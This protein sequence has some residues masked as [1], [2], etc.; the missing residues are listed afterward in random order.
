M[1]ELRH[2]LRVLQASP[3]F[4]VAALIVLA[5]GIGA[6][7]AIFALAD[8]LLIRPLPVH[9]PGRLV[10]LGMSQSGQPDTDYGFS[11]PAFK[12]LRDGVSDFA[13]VLAVSGVRLNVSYNG[14]NQRCLGEVVTGGYFAT[15]GVRPYLGRL[16][17]PA[18]DRVLG[19]HPVAVLDYAFWQRIGADPG[20]VGR[21]LLV[22]GRPL[23][24][25]G[26]T[27]REFYGTDRSLRPQLRVPM[28]MAP[29]LRPNA[30]DPTLSRRGHQW[31]RVM[32]R[33]KPGVSIQQA[34][35][36]ARAVFQGSIRARLEEM[37]ATVSPA[38]RRRAEGLRLELRSGAQ[39]SARLQ[40]EAGRPLLLLGGATLTLLIIACA[41]LANLLLARATTRAREFAVRSALGASRWQIARQL[42]AESLLLSTAAGALG[43]LGSFWMAGVILRFLPEGNALGTDLVPDWRVVAATFAIS[44]AAGLLFG[45]VP[46]VRAAL[47]APAPSLEADAPTVASADRLLSLRSVLIG[48]QVALSLVLLLGAGLFLRTLH[49]LYGVDTGFARDHVLAGTLDPTLNGYDAPRTAALLTEFVHRV[50]AIPGV[51]HAGLSSV[52]PITRSWDINSIAIA[53]YRSKTGEEPDAHFAAVS[54]GY[55]EAM[56]IAPKQ[57]RTLTWSDADGAPRVAVVNETMA[58]EYFDGAAVGRRFSM[59]DGKSEVEVVGVVPDGKYVDLREDRAP[60]F[61]YVSFLQ[62]PISGGELTLHARTDGNPLQYADAVKQRLRALD[63]TLPLAG[64]TTVEDQIA[65]SLSSERILA[66]LGSAFGALALLLAA[67]GI[68]GVL[69]L[70]VARR[71]REI[72]LRMAL[73]APPAGLVLMILRRLGAIVAAGLAAGLGGAWALQG[74]L[75]NILYGV[76]AADRAVVA[77]AV[78][79]V[80]TIGMLAAWFPARRAA[81]MDPI[82][83]LRHE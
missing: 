7:G 79:L 21:D 25:I 14:Q 1:S 83:A 24:V 65:E 13:G 34:T 39:G 22:N 44:L 64:V 33:L 82:A 52:S 36:S 78:A 80:A 46:A 12:D 57:G 71:T 59:D 41:N 30:S 74:V 10:I 45:V 5:I 9:A 81:R 3:T 11:Y 75:Q 62:A 60:R 27:P 19:G 16:L 4:T 18:D 28:A 51:R 47:R 66:T 17:T 61:A 72:G 54:P 76:T 2:A 6:N 15:L 77:G 32:A 26:V 42:L 68:H 63:P 37:P 53:G 73:G 31:L 43:L 58:R 29:T 48:A 50:E 20:L 23:T 70:A 69:A 35:T 55:L 8:A 49:N 67:V 56:G 38:A 40:R